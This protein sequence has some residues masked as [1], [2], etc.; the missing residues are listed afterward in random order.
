MVLI[1]YAWV[2]FV[3]L[4][5]SKG[6]LFAF[7]T[8]HALQSA[9]FGVIVSVIAIFYGLSLP[10]SLIPF[11]AFEFIVFL[12]SKR[13]AW[14]EGFERCMGYMFRSSMILFSA[15]VLA[16]GHEQAA[17][18]IVVAGMLEG[19]YIL[20]QK[21]VDSGKI[22]HTFHYNHKLG[23][24]VGTLGNPNMA[25]EF[26]LVTLI[27]ALWISQTWPVFFWSVPFIF[28]GL[29]FTAG[30]ATL[31]GSIVGAVFMG[32]YYP[33]SFAVSLPILLVLTYLLRKR[34]KI[35]K[36]RLLFW[37]VFMREKI[38]HP[39][40]I[41]GMGI[42]HYAQKLSDT[43]LKR[44]MIF[45]PLDRSHNWFMDLFIEGGIFYVGFFIFA[46]VA[47]LIYL[48]PILKCA[49]LV[50]LVCEFFSFPFQPNY[51]LWVFLIS[52]PVALPMPLWLL[53]PFL[54]YGFYVGFRAYLAGKKITSPS[55]SFLDS[56]HNMR[57]ALDWSP[58]ATPY[59]ANFV[60]SNLK[61]LGTLGKHEASR[62]DS[63]PHKEWEIHKCKAECAFIVKDFE[64]AKE[65]TEKGL[66]VAPGNPY[67]R[68]MKALLSGKKEPYVQTLKTL[69]EEFENCS[70]KSVSFE[71]PIWLDLVVNLPEKERE[72]FMKKYLSRFGRE[73]KINANKT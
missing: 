21:L 61:P 30:R 44:R 26:L 28:L 20:Y 1:L 65:E 52:I 72:E 5:V 8:V 45:H 35:D 70:G 55:K 68:R 3:T 16:V 49:L 51:L 17:I 37:K 29:V 33:I 62:I 25:S 54:A 69:I 40:R 41:E 46:N 48:P 63:Y 34:L 53:I 66:K 60:L 59:Y 6:P 24:F 32:F 10:I 12:F 71:T 43:E 56:Y 38:K 36:N 9:F 23:R 7:T 31:L 4:W 19:L 15:L 13:D 22:K 58:I 2:L 14:F 27:I 47:A 50:L 39:F 73:L 67:L 18:P 64:L 57:S 42:D 11:F